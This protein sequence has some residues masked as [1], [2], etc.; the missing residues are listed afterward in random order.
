LIAP[1]A[2]EM[3]VAGMVIASELKKFPFTPAQVPPTH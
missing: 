1:S 3:M 2:V